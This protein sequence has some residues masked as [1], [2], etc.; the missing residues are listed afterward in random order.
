MKL[1]KKIK[2]FLEFN[3]YLRIPDYK[4]VLKLHKSPARIVN[5]YLAK[6]YME[7]GLLHLPCA[8]WGIDIEPIRS[9]NLACPECPLTIES[10]PRK[11][12]SFERYKQILDPIAKYLF[13]VDFSY[14]G[15]PLL[16]PELGKMVAYAKQ[17][18]IATIVRSNL[19]YFPDKTARELV[20]CKCDI[21]LVGI[22]S[23]R[24]EAYVK[25]RKK[26]NVELVK[27]NLLKLK[28]LKSELKSVYPKIM[29][30]AVMT[31]DT[32]NDKD[33][34]RRLCVT[35]EGNGVFYAPNVIDYYL[36]REQDLLKTDAFCK[37]VEKVF[38]LDN[39]HVLYSKQ[40]S[41][42]LRKHQTLNCWMPYMYPALSAE[43]R[44]NG[45]WHVFYNED[46]IEEDGPAGS[47]WQPWNG[48]KAKNIRRYLKSRQTA[49]SLNVPCMR[50][51]KIKR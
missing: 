12:L 47:F 3:P 42:I 30:Y 24:Q 35:M 2:C 45:C 6:L 32:I 36:S 43:G 48:K 25:F 14:W 29:F 41:A 49:G 20:E 26:G 44:L 4:G 21:I 38:P 16:N 9:C 40:G 23:P 18:K 11:K 51:T 46:S 37:E 15:E 39:K 8:P 19:N 33:E 28:N 13:M 27:Q 10:Y 50:C 5:Y 34:L 31:Q 22:D 7:L 17:K 1:L